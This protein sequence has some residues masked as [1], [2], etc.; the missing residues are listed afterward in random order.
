[1]LYTT[2]LTFQEASTNIALG[3]MITC[4]ICLQLHDARYHV[5]SAFKGACATFVMNAIMLIVHFH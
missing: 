1:M 2:I 5:M 3:D 4:N